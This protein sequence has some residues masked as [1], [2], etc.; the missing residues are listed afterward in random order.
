MLYHF[1]APLASDVSAFN[2]FRYITFRSMG[3]LITAMVISVLIG[4]AFISFLH[5]IK[6]G[7][8]ILSDVKAHASKAGT[9]TMGGL[10]IMLC[11]FATILLWA[12]LGSRYIWQTMLHAITTTLSLIFLFVRK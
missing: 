8:Y 10:M 1:L 3:A 5:R 11:V 2:V 7:Q 12:D 4:P 9:P 6:V